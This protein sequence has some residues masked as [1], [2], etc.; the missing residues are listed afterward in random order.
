[1]ASDRDEE[2]WGLDFAGASE[3]DV[4]AILKLAKDA[5]LGAYG[6]VVNPNYFLTRHFD[7]STAE[8]LLAALSEGA[9]EV[10]DDNGL[11]RRVSKIELL[12]GLEGVI[13]DL[14]QFVERAEP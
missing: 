5:G 8:W 6:S 2:Y 14:A 10:H 4:R 12:E 13:Y 9:S 1:M 7:R 11:L 3:E